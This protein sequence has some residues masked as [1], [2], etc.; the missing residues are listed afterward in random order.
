MVP[1]RGFDRSIRYVPPAEAEDGYYGGIENT[2]I[3]A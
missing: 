2:E 1:L 3:A